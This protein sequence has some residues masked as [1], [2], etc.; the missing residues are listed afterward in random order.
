VDAG[1][2]ISLYILSPVRRDD[3]D[4]RCQEAVARREVSPWGTLLVRD[5]RLNNTPG[6]APVLKKVFSRLDPTWQAEVW[7]LTQGAPPAVIT[8]LAANT[9]RFTFGPDGYFYYSAGSRVRWR[10]R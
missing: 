4:D 1:K 8:S 2:P 6:A 5:F 7:E 3:S 10:S 9:F